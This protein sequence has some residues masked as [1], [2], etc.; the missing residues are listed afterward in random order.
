MDYCSQVAQAAETPLYGTAAQFRVGLLL[1]YG[2]EWRNKAISNNDLPAEIMTWLTAVSVSI[3]G[4]RPLFIGKGGSRKRSD[5]R[6]KHFY[7]TVND[8]D[9]P[10]VYCF[11][12]TDYAELMDID[13][14]AVVEGASAAE[15]TSETV[16]AVCTNGKHDAC[17]A[18]FGVPIYRALEQEFEHDPDV[19]VWQCTHIGGH[20]Y[21]ATAAILPSGVVYGY[22]TPENV[23]TVAEAIRNNQVH[24]PCYRG[25]TIYEGIVNAA[26]YYLRE[27]TGQTGLGALTLVSAEETTSD[28][29]G[30]SHWRVEFK[31]GSSP[32]HVV[33]VAQ[34]M[35]DP[36]F[37][38]CGD[39]PPKPQ[40]AYRLENKLMP[41]EAVP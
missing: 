41:V 1:E 17:C 30:E 12:F 4:S 34:S 36:V 22:L 14:A 24:L 6:S 3:P 5:D 16:I 39:K 9:A 29:Q 18:K 19:S 7:V 32:H 23:S 11:S 21:A 37:S 20:R 35:T 13:V 2:G 38:S 26:E 27:A 31:N 25:R 40:V 8:V 15:P 10:R 33:E 28:P